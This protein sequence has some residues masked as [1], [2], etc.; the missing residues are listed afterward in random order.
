VY[1]DSIFEEKNI[2]DQTFIC[3]TLDRKTMRMHKQTLFISSI[4]AE[5]S[6]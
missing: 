2:N 5:V 3:G 6:L 4:R 1:Q